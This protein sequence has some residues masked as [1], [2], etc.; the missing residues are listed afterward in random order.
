V[1][2]VRRDEIIDYATYEDGREELRKQVLALKQPRRVHVGDSV[3]LLFETTDTVR[4][5]VQE[6]IRVEKM[7]RESEIQHELET[8]NEILGDHG[9]LGCTMLIEID[10][11]VVR[12]RKLREWLTLPQR[13]FAELEGGERIAAKFDPRQVGEDRVSSVQFLKFSTGGRTP[14]AFVIDHP[15][16]QAR[17]LLSKE[18]HAAL[19]EDLRA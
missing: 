16:L 14:I 9:E 17:A 4:Y 18:Q 11:P 1:R 6:M 12:D 2:K 7:V 15:A 10:D 19:S 8:Y 5:Q 13:I 3:T